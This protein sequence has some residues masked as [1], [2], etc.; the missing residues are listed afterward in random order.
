MHAKARETQAAHSLEIEF[1]GAVVEQR[2]IEADFA[3]RIAREFVDSHRLIEVQ[4][5]VKE[6]DLERQLG[7]APERSLGLEANVAESVVVDALQILGQ[8]GLLRSIGLRGKLLC[9]MRH[10]VEVEAERGPRGQRDEQRD[11]RGATMSLHLCRGRH[12]SRASL[13]PLNCHRAEA[14]KK[15]R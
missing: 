5:E 13:S 4:A 2:G 11:G 9:A 8:L 3:D 7:V 6:R 15:L 14:G 1:V 10:F 12:R